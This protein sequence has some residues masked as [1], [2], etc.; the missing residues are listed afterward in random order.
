MTW[1][2]PR[3][4]CWWQL[5][6]HRARSAEPERNVQ[7][8]GPVA[9]ILKQ[10]QFIGNSIF[11]D[12]RPTSMPLKIWDLA[13]QFGPFRAVTNAL[14]DSV[15]LMLHRSVLRSGDVQE[16]GDG[17]RTEQSLKRV[18]LTMRTVVVLLRP[19]PSISIGACTSLFRICRMCQV[20]LT[21][22]IWSVWIT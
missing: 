8:C 11:C 7:G 2:P 10:W 20:F 13:H 19:S 14:S 15:P 5:V 22:F 3:T 21:A 6:Y 12:L 16:F 1:L 4:W 17:I 9:S 18:W